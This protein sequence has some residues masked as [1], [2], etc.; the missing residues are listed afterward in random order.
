[1]FSVHSGA[2]DRNVDVHRLRPESTSPRD[3]LVAVAGGDAG[4]GDADVRDR[5][6]GAAMGRRRASRRHLRR[7]SGPAQPPRRRPARHSSSVRRRFSIDA[8]KVGDTLRLALCGQRFHFDSEPV[9]GRPNARDRPLGRRR[10]AA[11]AGRRTLAPRIRNRSAGSCGVGLP[12]AFAHPPPRRFSRRRPLRLLRQN[13]VKL[14]KLGKTTVPEKKV[15]VSWV[16][17]FFSILQ[18][19]SVILLGFWIFLAFLL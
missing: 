12:P 3:A 16:S 6:A 15:L 9:E 2:A 13:Q 10:D 18:V 14:G 8:S 5:P 4:R 17:L 11:A 7:V 1:M 19:L